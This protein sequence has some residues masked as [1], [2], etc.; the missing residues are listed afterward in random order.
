MGPRGSLN[1]GNSPDSWVRMAVRVGKQPRLLFLICTAW[2]CARQ[3]RDARPMP[4]GTRDLE[5]ARPRGTPWHIEGRGAARH[6]HLHAQIVPRA[7]REPPGRKSSRVVESSRALPSTAAHHATSVNVDQVSSRLGRRLLTAQ[8][9][10][11]VPQRSLQMDQAMTPR[12]LP[13][14]N[15]TPRQTVASCPCE[16]HSFDNYFCWAFSCC[17]RAARQAAQRRR[18]A[19]MIR[20][21]PS[22]L[23][24]RLRGAAAA[25][26]A[27]AVGAVAAN[28]TAPA[29]AAR[30]GGR[31]RRLYTR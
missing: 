27:A 24:R 13:E 4:E 9:R 1:R 18:A 2:Y 16:T 29:R 23:M 17:A 14:N 26:S 11:G 28:A 15:R 19:S 21:R 25:V 6:L 22:G 10:P 3:A 5:Y 8:K 20:R 7:W 31:P 30:P 12:A